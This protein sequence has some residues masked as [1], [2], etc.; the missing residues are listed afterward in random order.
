ML[1]M[2]NKAVLIWVLLTSWLLVIP[3]TALLSVAVAL[4]AIGSP[5]E[6][7]KTLVGEFDI[8][9]CWDFKSI[10]RAWRGADNG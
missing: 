8:D 5:F 9:V 3:L 1:I 7:F 6:A 4:S 2:K 10:I